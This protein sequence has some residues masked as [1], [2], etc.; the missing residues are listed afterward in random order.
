[1]NTLPNL[2]LVTEGLQ[3]I[4]DAARFL[5]VSRSLLYRL[6]NAGVLPTVRIG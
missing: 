6:I 1:M 2:E 4:S 3:R 5:G